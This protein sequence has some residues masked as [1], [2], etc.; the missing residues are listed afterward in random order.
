MIVKNASECYTTNFK[1]NHPI[2]AVV[3][4]Q[5]HAYFFYSWPQIG[6]F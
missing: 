3:S 2:N 4:E 1:K 6:L 5:H